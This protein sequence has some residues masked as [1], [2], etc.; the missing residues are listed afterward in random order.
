MG[1]RAIRHGTTRGQRDHLRYQKGTERSDTVRKGA[2]KSY[3]ES[4]EGREIVYGTKM[5]QGDHMRNQKE[6]ERSYAEQKR[7]REV[8]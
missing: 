4:K 2:E 5:G 3:K 6:V 1:E 8:K 7:D